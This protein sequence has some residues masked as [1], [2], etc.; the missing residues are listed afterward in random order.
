MS[1]DLDIYKY[2]NIILTPSGKQSTRLRVDNLHAFGQRVYVDI[3][4]YINIILTPSSRQ[5]TRLRVDNLHAQGG[6]K[7]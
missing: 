2:I 3:Y 4:T 6:L 5:S 7:R 1:T